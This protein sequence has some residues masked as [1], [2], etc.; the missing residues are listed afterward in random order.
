MTTTLV[1]VV[2]PPKADLD[3]LASAVGVFAR[4]ARTTFSWLYQQGRGAAEVKRAVCARF[5]ILARHWSGCRAVSQAAA[6]SWREGGAERLRMLE[7][8]IQAL[9]AR[10]PKDAECPSRKRRNAVARRKA[11][12]AAA[13]V[14]KELAGV[15]RWCFGGR[16]LLRRGRLRKWRRRRD[17]QALFC[18]ETGK[19]AGNEVAQWSPDGVLRLRLPDACSRTHLVLRDVRFSAVRQ[20]FLESAVDAR[21]PV[22]WRVKLLRRGKVQLCV[23]FDE[24]EPEL[25][26]DPAAGAVG[27]DLNR[28]HLAVVDVAP[29]GRVAGAVRLAL[30]AGSD[31]VWRVAKA[32]VARARRAGRPVVLENLDFRSDKAWLR[33]YG[34]RF[35]E[36]LSIFRSRQLRDAVE[37]EAGRAGIEVRYVD[38]AWTSE[39]GSLK[40]R[41]RCRLG[42]HHA[43]ALVIGRRG[44]GFGERLLD[45]RSTLTR[46][47]ECVGT[48]GEERAFVQRL[49]AAW[50][51]GGRRRHDRRGRAPRALVAGS[52]ASQPDGPSAG[53]GSPAAVGG[54]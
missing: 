12:V 22:T 2:R 31:A 28:N 39:L 48:S 44:L 49:P 23:T 25:V 18:G 47:V 40:Y 1:V 41:R 46:T 36:V 8:R 20:S 26:S 5:G 24:P 15:P 17:S 7:Q 42:R 19:R 13:R 10:W 37:R 14:H 35:A 52:R 30:R 4:A 53:D 16:R 38:P 21:S 50:L 51:Q 43:A 6:R 11:E 29:D 32:V 54:A 33:S 27:V 3:V 45:G 34:K 9:D